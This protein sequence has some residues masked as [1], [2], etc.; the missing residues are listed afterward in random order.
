MTTF[1]ESFSVNAHQ[2]VP[3][4]DQWKLY[5][6]NTD[7]VAISVVGGGFGLNG[8]GIDTFEMWDFRESDPQGYLTASE[9]NEHLQKYP[10]TE[11]EGLTEA[12]Y[13]DDDESDKIMY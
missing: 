10:V 11:L 7:R 13:F 6:P 4:A 1:P 5:Y 12:D 9:I 8:D 3:G 2:L